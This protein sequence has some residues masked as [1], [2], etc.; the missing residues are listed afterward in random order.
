MSEGN[1]KR[2]NLTCVLLLAAIALLVLAPGIGLNL[3]DRDE[4]WYS[5]IVREMR[6]TG[7]WLV[8][9]YLGKV[10]LGKP[11]M[12]YWLVGLSTR[13]LGWGEW[14]ARLVPVLASVANVL[15]IAWLATRLFNRRVGVWSGAI[16]I[17]F[18]MATAIGKLLLVDAVLLTF[19]LTA[20]VLQW[21]MATAGVTHT[22]AALHGLAIGLGVLTKGP[23]IIIFAGAFV[24]ALLVAYPERWRTWLG[25]WRWWVWGGLLAIG[26]GA[27]WYLYM[28]RV[29][30]DTFVSQFITYELTSRLASRT[31]GGTP[32][33]PGFYVVAA[34]VCLLPWSPCVPGALRAAIHNRRLDPAYPLLLT[35][36][37]LPWAFL[38]IIRGKVLSYPLPCYAALAILLAAELTRRFEASAS[39]DSLKRSTRWAFRLACLPLL[40]AGSLILLAGLVYRHHTWGCAT[41]TLGA[42]CTIGYLIALYLL[43]Q[44]GLRA[45]CIAIL[46]ATI[47]MQATI[48]AVLNPSL[49]SLGFSRRA[50]EGINAEARPGEQVVL[51]GYKEP[52]LYLYTR[53][54]IKTIDP[55][56][57]GEFVESARL[58][59]PVLLAVYERDLEMIEKI[60]AKIK[61]DLSTS[62][63]PHFVREIT[64]YTHVKKIRWDRK[65]DEYLIRPDRM[66]L[67]RLGR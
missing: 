47:A 56:V 26:V 57:L 18:G 10:W 4:G 44:R 28:Y 49:D 52:T 11:P 7:D 51:C 19:I 54:P 63:R 13:L 27:P 50:A 38:E 61:Q 34:L 21:R 3:T 41:I 65:G 43:R 46:A 16:F 14:Q 58:G 31:Q 29:A 5:Q 15:L 35:W 37:I 42:V 20:I 53:E 40:F 48:G 60:D 1:A 22:R 36:L 30:H 23:V 32:G 39:W 33:Y 8:P 59:P 45:G 24:P 9:R 17:T 62:L 67:A 6:N 12:L 66:Y 25:N 55:G 2:L 64:G